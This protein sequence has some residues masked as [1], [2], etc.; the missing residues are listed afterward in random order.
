M[1]TAVYERIRNNPKF[2][3]L[4]SKRSR[5]A[6]TLTAIVLTIYFSFILVVAFKPAL[7]ATPI[8][9]GG[10]ASIAWPI[11]AGMILLFWLMTGLYIYRANG[12]FDDI[13]A[14]V[15]KGAIE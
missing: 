12:E 3:E 5:F 15:I 13:N 8:W 4:V 10:T 14:E 1:S 2:D 9:E 11:G 6:W 7:L